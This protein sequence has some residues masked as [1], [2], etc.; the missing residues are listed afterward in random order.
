L[1]KQP[2]KTDS[3]TPC[4]C[5]GTMKIKMV[6]PLPEEPD[7]M[8]HTFVCTCGETASFKYPKSGSWQ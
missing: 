8:Q 6:E 7:M 2:L 4:E 1:K 5:G 3:T